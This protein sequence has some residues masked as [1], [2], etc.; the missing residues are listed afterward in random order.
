MPYLCRNK[1]QTEMTAIPNKYPQGFFNDK[2]CKRCKTIFSP[3]A[4]SHM[5]CGQDCADYG[6]NSRYLMNNYGI[7]LDDY[8]LVHKD[9]GGVCAICK[10]EGFTMA[11]HHRLKLVV[12]HCHSTGV[13]RGLLCHN[14]NRGIGLLQESKD[15]FLN[16]IKYL[17]SA[18]T[19]LNRSTSET[20]ADGSA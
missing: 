20:N 13:V 7:S 3:A 10:L 15:N 16:S 19:I 18:E 2:P 8:W 4:P 14:C 12:D 1:P 5:Y 11:K 17:E 6:L 9:Q